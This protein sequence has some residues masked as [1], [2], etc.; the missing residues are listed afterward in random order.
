[1][2]IKSIPVEQIGYL[3]T[4]QGVESRLVFADFG[5]FHGLTRRR[6]GHRHDAKPVVDFIYLARRYPSTEVPKKDHLS[7]PRLL[8]AL[9]CLNFGLGES[10]PQQESCCDATILL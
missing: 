7:S 5:T 1:M 4:K 9:Y 3:E 2:P 10:S 6:G 8:G